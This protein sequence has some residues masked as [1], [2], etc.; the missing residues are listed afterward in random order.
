[1]IKYI[2]PYEYKVLAYATVVASCPEEAIKLVEQHA[3]PCEQ[4]DFEGAEGSPLEEIVFEELG[5]SFRV[6]KDD[7]VFL[8]Q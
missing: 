6:I 1:M 8:E 3:P 4:D 7:I 5:E 2:V